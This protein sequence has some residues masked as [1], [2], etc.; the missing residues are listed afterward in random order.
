MTAFPLKKNIFE[1]FPRCEEIRQFLQIARRK[2]L[3]KNSSGLDEIHWSHAEIGIDLDSKPPYFSVVFFHILLCGRGRHIC[4]DIQKDRWSYPY[5]SPTI[6][7]KKKKKQNNWKS[8]SKRFVPSVGGT[9]HTFFK[10][11]W[12]C[13]API[14][15]IGTIGAHMMVRCNSICLLVSF[16]QSFV[17]ILHLEHPWTG[18]VSFFSFKHVCRFPCS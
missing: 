13:F 14:L 9:I 15:I 2:V 1:W 3:A 6:H 12:Q 11:C 5:H 8:S 4:C 10:A 17:T 7:I 18:C 16:I